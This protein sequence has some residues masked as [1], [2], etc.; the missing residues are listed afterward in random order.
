MVVSVRCA[1]PDRCDDPVPYESFSDAS[2]DDMD[3]CGYMVAHCDRYER[4]VGLPDHIARMKRSARRLGYECR[5]SEAEIRRCVS[6]LLYKTGYRPARF[7]IVA[8]RDGALRVTVGPYTP[9]SEE[10]LEKGV[11]CALVYGAS[12]LE[13]EVKSSSWSRTRE[14]LLAHGGGGSPPE[15][16]YEYLLVDEHGR[17]LEGSSSNFFAV[18]GAGDSAMLHTAAEG[19]LSGITRSRV[20]ECA[21]GII[22]VS[23]DPVSEAALGQVS[24]AFITSSTRGVVPVR[25]IGERFFGDRGVWTGAI[26][27]AY[28]R[29]VETNAE[30]LYSP[31]VDA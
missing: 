27:Q 26:Q 3:A 16:V 30:V 20:L 25:S 9:P 29:W 24:E 7:R 15:A 31:E 10:Q 17:I 1:S 22:P 14:R 5:W 4:V 11:D 6:L 21:A 2:R 12:R 28:R 19:V 8:E 18:E 23:Y 13:A